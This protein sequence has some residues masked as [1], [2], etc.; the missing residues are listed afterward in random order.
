MV[1][2]TCESDLH[3][4]LYHCG[5]GVGVCVYGF[6]GQSGLSDGNENGAQNGGGNPYPLQRFGQRK[7]TA[8]QVS[9]GTLYAQMAR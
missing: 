1:D 2:F 4:Q 7:R 8:S 9:S 6:W 3:H 5:N